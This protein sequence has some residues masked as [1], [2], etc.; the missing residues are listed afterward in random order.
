MGER[1]THSSRQKKEKKEKQLWMR[2]GRVIRAP[3]LC[4]CQSCNSPVA[5]FIDSWLAGR[6][7]NPADNA[8]VDFISQS[9]IYEFGYWVRSRNP[10]TQW[11][12]RGGS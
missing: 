12:L 5:E 9:G 11:N 8:G 3:W 7:D 2:S 1:L 10:P 4:H 6:Y